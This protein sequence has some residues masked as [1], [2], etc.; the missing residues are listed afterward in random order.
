VPHVV[1]DVLA[2][3]LARF[4]TGPDG[5]VLSASTGSPAT[6]GTLRT[7]L[8][9]SAKRAAL[10]K[11]TSPHDARHHYASLLIAS[12]CSVKVVQS[13]L[14]HATARESLDT[15][16]HLWP[17]DDARTVEAVD[18]ALGELLGAESVYVTCTR[19]DSQGSDLRRRA[20]T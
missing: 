16:S 7:V 12:G 3:H 17:D 5:L 4:G 1:R 14:G 19:P 8:Y 10:P 20:Q 18:N 2:A 15:Y 9:H 6:T 13:R 11:G